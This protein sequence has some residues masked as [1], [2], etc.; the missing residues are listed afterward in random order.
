MSCALWPYWVNLDY[1]YGC[2]TLASL[3]PLLAHASLWLGSTS[4]SGR[5]E[6]RKLTGQDVQSLPSYFK[7]EGMPASRDDLYY[8]GHQPLAPY[9]PWLEDTDLAQR[10]ADAWNAVIHRGAGTLSSVATTSVTPLRELS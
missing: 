8:H 5:R 9:L 2:N 10:I 1:A 6:T 3:R 4:D 7:K